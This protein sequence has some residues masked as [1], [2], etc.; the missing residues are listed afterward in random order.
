MRTILVEKG[1]WM[2]LILMTSFVLITGCIIQC[3]FQRPIAD[4]LKDVPKGSHLEAK[5]KE[6]ARR[7]LL[8][9]P[10]ILALL[11]LVLLTCIP[12]AILICFCYFFQMDAR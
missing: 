3:V 11:N 10:F 9:L 7:R 6:I 12:A 5:L 8:N 4:A 1:G 2:A